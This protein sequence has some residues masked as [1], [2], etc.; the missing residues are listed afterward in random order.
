MIRNFKFLRDNYEEELDLPTYD[1]E[2]NFAS[3]MWVSR[4]NMDQHWE[5]DEM[6]TTSI[7]TF[8]MNFPEQMIVPILSI[9]GDNITMTIDNDHD[10][11]PFN[12]L[13][14]TSLQII[15]LKWVPNI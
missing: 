5:I 6:V 9:T 2:P 7:R 4:H 3:W 14:G 13:G 10:P 11:W 1:I 8:L 15:Y 12:I